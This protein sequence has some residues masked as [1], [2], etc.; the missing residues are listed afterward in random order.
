LDGIVFTG[1]CCRLQGLSQ[2]DDGRHSNHNQL[3]GF[4][5]FCLNLILLHS[6]CVRRLR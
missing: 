2:W 4:G 3:Y 6:I 5:T 1:G